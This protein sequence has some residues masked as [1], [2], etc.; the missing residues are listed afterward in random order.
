MVVKTIPDSIL[1][2]HL[3]LEMVYEALSAYREY[4][5]VSARRTECGH[6]LSVTEVPEVGAL[7]VTC[8]MGCTSYR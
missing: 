1:A 5:T 8:D 2:K 7:W 6:V 3:E 4:C